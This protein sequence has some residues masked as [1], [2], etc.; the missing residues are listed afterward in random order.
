MSGVF[1]QV[2]EWEQSAQQRVERLEATP[3]DQNGYTLLEPY[4]KKKES[5]EVLSAQKLG[6]RACRESEKSARDRKSLSLPMESI[7]RGGGA[8]SAHIGVGTEV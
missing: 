6:P 1:A 5:E 3:A 2:T 8:R 7:P 4:L